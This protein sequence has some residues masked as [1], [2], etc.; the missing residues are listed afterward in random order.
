MNCILTRNKQ[1]DYPNIIASC[2]HPTSCIITGAMFHF[3][4][5]CNVPLQYCWKGKPYTYTGLWK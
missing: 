1:S 5:T 4:P 2:Y 3:Y